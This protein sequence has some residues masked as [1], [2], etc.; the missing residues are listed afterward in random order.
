MIDKTLKIFRILNFKIFGI[1]YF[2][3]NYLRLLGLKSES[4]IHTKGLK[5][6]WPHKVK[7]GKNVLL[8]PNVIFKHDGPYSLGISIEI[9]DNIFIGTACEFNIRK[10]IIIGS[11]CLIA[12]GCKFIDHDHGVSKTEL[13]RTQYGKEKEI[14]IEEDVWLG[15]NVVVLKG[16]KIG[17]GAIVGAGAIVTKSIPPYEIWAGI[18]A[19]KISERT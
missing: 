18:P 7:L 6:T 4:P 1:N 2:K 14:I 16:V 9:G 12:S 17:K 8:E 3:Y 13:M 10:S 11:N 15:V 5:M 19:N